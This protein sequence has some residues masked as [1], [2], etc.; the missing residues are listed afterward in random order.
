ME[1]IMVSDTAKTRV[2]RENKQK[3]MG[4]KRKNKLVNT[5]STKSQEELFGSKEPKENK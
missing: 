1:K 2:I 5:G 4:R 3:K